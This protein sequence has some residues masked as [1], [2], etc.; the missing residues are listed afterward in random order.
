MAGTTP[1][2]AWPYPTGTDLVMN[3]DNA[4]EALA[5]ATETTIT[6]KDSASCT[7]GPN[8]TLWGGTVVLRTGGWGTLCVSYSPSLAMANGA[9]VATLPVGFRPG[10]EIYFTVVDLLAASNF[11]NA[12]LVDSSGQVKCMRADASTQQHVGSCSFPIQR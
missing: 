4:M 9:V 5:R 6:T 12:L 2:F 10:N 8:V 7:A 3:G 1:K 11:A